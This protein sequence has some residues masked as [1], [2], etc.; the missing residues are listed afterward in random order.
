MKANDTN[1]VVA[2]T[3]GLSLYFYRQLIV[4][5]VASASYL[6]W[7]GFSLELSLCVGVCP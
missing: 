2:V 7:D 1:A 5:I 3:M 4:A 6:R